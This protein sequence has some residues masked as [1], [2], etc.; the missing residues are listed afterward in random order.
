MAT[1]IPDDDRSA[2]DPLLANGWVLVN[3]R[4]AISKQFVFQ[5][6]V[7]AFGWMSWALI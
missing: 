2:L 1:K 3:G 6:F 7:S 4:D 5:N